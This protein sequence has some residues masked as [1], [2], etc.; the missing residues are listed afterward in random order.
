MLQL[1][2]EVYGKEFLGYCIKVKVTLSYIVC[3]I[4]MSLVLLNHNEQ[5]YEVTQFPPSFSH[6]FIVEWCFAIIS[7][8]AR[9]TTR[10]GLPRFELQGRRRGGAAVLS[11]RTERMR[12]RKR[13]G[14][15][16]YSGHLPVT[17]SKFNDPPSLYVICYSTVRCIH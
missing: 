1:I 5:K 17:S 15:I 11:V 7:F 9:Q 14:G 10:D 16:Q 8:M 3:H 4:N 6:H 12:G 13:L 2:G